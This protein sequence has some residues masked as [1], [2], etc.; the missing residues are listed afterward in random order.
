MQFF[1][2]V[3]RIVGACV[4]S[5]AP[6]AIRS[7][8]IPSCTIPAWRTINDDSTAFHHADDPRGFPTVSTLPRPPVAAPWESRVSS[9][10]FQSNNTD[11]ES[12]SADSCT[13]FDRRRHRGECCSLGHTLRFSY[14][15]SDD[16]SFLLMEEQGQLA[17]QFFAV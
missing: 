9:V 4:P 17:S 10:P 13:T 15:H 8:H 2:S 7:S 14:R 16:G 6:C 11:Y 12:P 3:T 5:V 1:G